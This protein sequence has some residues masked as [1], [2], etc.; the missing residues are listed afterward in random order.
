[1]VREL[2]LWSQLEHPN[3]LPLLGFYLEGANAIP[4][5]ISEWMING[6]VTMYIRNRP[7]D[8]L[9]LIYIVGIASG[10]CYLHFE[11]SIVHSDLKG[12]N[13]LVSDDGRPLL[14]D[15]GL[16]ISPVSVSLAA[17]AGHGEK[18]STRWMAKELFLKGACHS[19]ETDLWAFGM[20]IFVRYILSIN[21]EQVNDSNDNFRNF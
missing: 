3:V 14:A 13:I 2:R 6:T 8:V 12:S 15:F 5:L 4:N 10:L 16:S 21:L 17:T 11:K 7:F 18:G 20:V 9:E 19:Q 1:L